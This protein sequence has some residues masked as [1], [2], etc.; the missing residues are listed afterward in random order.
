[1]V[2]LQVRGGQDLQPDQLAKLQQW[3]DEFMSLWGMKDTS[4]P[5]MLFRVGYAGEPAVR[6]LRRPLNEFMMDESQTALFHQAGSR[7]PS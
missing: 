3:K 4:G 7:E 2:N 5:L 1:M 6:T